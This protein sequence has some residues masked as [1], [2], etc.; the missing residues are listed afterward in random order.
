MKNINE[1]IKKAKELQDKLAR[2]QEEL[3]ELEVTGESQQFVKVKM[4]G[5]LDIIS[6]EISEEALKT[7]DKEMLEDTITAAFRD[8]QQKVKAIAKEKMA[9]IGL[10]NGIPGIDFPNGIN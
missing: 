8:A 7:L 9:E 2:V 10:T 4:N 5:K 3:D 6:I 1:I